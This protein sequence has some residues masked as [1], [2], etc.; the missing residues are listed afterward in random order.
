MQYSAVTTALQG[1]F[2]L[3]YC[4]AAALIDGRVDHDTFSPE[5]FARGDIQGLMTRVHRHRS[6][7]AR[8]HSQRTAD[9]IDVDVLAI[10]FRGQP[11][12]KI[13]LGPR[14]VLDGDEVEK[15]F[16]ANAARGR[17]N[18]PARQLVETVRDLPNAG[19]VASLMTMAAAPDEE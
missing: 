9:G 12:R 1:K 7:E 10:E 18:A 13:K 8:L 6:P 16:L 2:S 15:K 14:R 3:E 11:V 17:V 19:S 5:R 4:V